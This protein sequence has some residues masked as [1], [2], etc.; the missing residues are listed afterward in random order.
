MSPGVYFRDLTLFSPN[1][2]LLAVR[3]FLSSCVSIT[4]KKTAK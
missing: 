3:N 2:Q 4:I 1:G